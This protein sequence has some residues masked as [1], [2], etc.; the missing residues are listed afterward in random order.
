MTTK[1]TLTNT[2]ASH[3]I[4]TIDQLKAAGIDLKILDHQPFGPDIDR[5][6]CSV[7]LSDDDGD[8]VKV[9]LEALLH[10]NEVSLDLHEVS[11]G[12]LDSDFRDSPS[13]FEESIALHCICQDAIT[14]AHLETIRSQLKAFRADIA[15]V[16]A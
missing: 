12:S 16:D 14:V 13:D 6:T 11:L 7:V 15:A 1:A 8:L 4:P 9:D 3:T 10:Q 2:T 5:F